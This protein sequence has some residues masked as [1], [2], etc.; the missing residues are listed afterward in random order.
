MRTLTTQ[1]WTVRNWFREIV[2]GERKYSVTGHFAIELLD[3]AYVPNFEKIAE[4]IRRID[5]E[6][7]WK[8][9][10]HPS[11]LGLV[12]ENIRIVSKGEVVTHNL[13]PP[14]S[15]YWLTVFHSHGSL[16]RSQVYAYEKYLAKIAE[17]LMKISRDFAKE[18]R[19]VIEV[20]AGTSFR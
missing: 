18:V 12:D 14:L 17:E 16:R 3:H 10:L 19:S 15:I 6:F 1:A 11:V 20:R 9:D 5:G 7:P 13:A 4:E 2:D 8:V